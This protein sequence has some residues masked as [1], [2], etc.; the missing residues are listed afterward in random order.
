M[1]ENVEKVLFNDSKEVI[2]VK[3]NKR[4][5]DSDYVILSGGVIGTCS[6]L[7]R[8]KNEKSMN[9][10]LR[11]NNREID[12]LILIKADGSASY[13]FAVAVDDMD[14]KISLL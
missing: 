4:V 8:G 7:L 1:G 11:I 10:L 6:L 12:D 14:M 9:K 3:T 13:N 2:G 5:I